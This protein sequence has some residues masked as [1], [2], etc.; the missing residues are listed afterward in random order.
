MTDMQGRNSI[1][2]AALR[3]IFDRIISEETRKRESAENLK[4]IYEEAKS[5]GFDLPAL[6]ETVKAHWIAEDARKRA[7]AESKAEMAQI[8]ADALQLRLF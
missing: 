4:E 3:A 1:D 6:K 5:Q 7:K 2:D 8:Y